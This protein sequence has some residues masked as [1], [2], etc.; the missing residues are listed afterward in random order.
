MCA[1]V[2]CSIQPYVSKTTCGQRDARR[3]RI[4][5]QDKSFDWPKRKKMPCVGAL[6]D[7][8]NASLNAQKDEQAIVKL[9]AFD[10]AGKG[11]GARQNP[12]LCRFRTAFFALH[13]RS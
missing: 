10:L 12:V 3:P 1:S 6:L 9:F 13:K 2:A 4:Q 7:S 5:K 11:F 8:T